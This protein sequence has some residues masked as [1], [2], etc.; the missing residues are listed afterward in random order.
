MS[1]DAAHPF[2]ARRLKAWR[3][4]Y[5][6]RPNV[7]FFLMDG[8][9]VY[10]A[11][12]GVYHPEYD[13]H[14]YKDIRL[15]RV[16]A[17]PINRGHDDESI[18]FGTFTY[19]DV[20]LEDCRPGRDPL[21]QLACTSPSEGQAGHFR[22]ITLLK[23]ASRSANVVDLGGGPRNDKLQNGVAYF[24]HDMPRE[25]LT[26]KVVS[27]K[28]EKTLKS[29]DYRAMDGFTG[30]DVRAAA[31][32]GVEF[33]CL[34][35]P[36]D[37]LPPASA[38]LSVRRVGARLAVRGISHDNGEIVSISVNGAPARIVSLSAGVAD[39]EAAV[40]IPADGLISA[41]AADKVGNVEETPH[42]VR[43][44]EKEGGGRRARL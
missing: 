27:V 8:L 26:T 38:I 15:N 16:D 1:G 9:H 33:P 29:G 35:D 30:K 44:K 13:A 18:Q 24:F 42:R 34:L 37:D 10:G 28:F 12:Y 4:H 25:G 40:E 31:V 11:A 20:T 39:W 22:N 2:I 3:T 7:S 17:E 32:S 6:L 19:E 36:V 43:F 21:I 41:G 5:A 14:V 23:S